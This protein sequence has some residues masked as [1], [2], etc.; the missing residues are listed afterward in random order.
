MTEAEALARMIPPTGHRPSKPYR[1]CV[2]QIHIT[3]ACDKACF[4]CLQGSHLGGKTYFMSPEHF[5][6]AL[7]SLEGFTG[8]VGVFGGNPALSP[9]FETY[10]DLLA[11]YF[12][13]EQRGL[14]CNNPI[15]PEKARKMRATYDPKVSNL[16]CHLDQQAHDLFRTYWP[17]SMP[18]GL[19]QDSRH[20]PPWV[21]LKDIVPDE[22]ERWALI[23]ACDLNQR[24]SASMGV[25]RGQLRA[26][27]CE[28]AMAQSVVY[29]DD[30]EYPDTGLDPTVEY[31]HEVAPGDKHAT[32]IGKWWELGMHSFRHQVRHHCHS[33]GIPLKG[34]GELAQRPEGEG[35]EQVSATHQDV[36]RPK[37]KGRRV[38][39][40]TVRSQLG[41]PLDNPTKYI[42][43][44]SK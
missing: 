28:E 30:P 1:G 5:E 44:A 31:E 29:Q 20:S 9:Y 25:F 21:A 34:H 27:F 19:T 2:V 7:Q 3:R 32:T 14:W 17:E 39:L 10:C 4:G 35:V 42:Q 15:T 16:N 41:E 33:C 6:Q 43:N 11:K 37:R 23:A 18:F 38:E 26:W 36:Y 13:R 40:V 8:V 12:P 24:W 22:G